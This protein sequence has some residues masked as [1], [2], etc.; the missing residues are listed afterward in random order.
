MREDFREPRRKK[1]LKEKFNEN[2]KKFN[3]F[4]NWAD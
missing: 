4:E 1:D 3:Q 2:R